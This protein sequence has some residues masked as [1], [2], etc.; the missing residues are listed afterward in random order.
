LIFRGRWEYT[1]DGILDRSH[2]RFFTLDSIQGMLKE[3]GY[4]TEGL[5]KRSSGAHWVRWIHR[6][7]GSRLIEF[8]VRQYIIV[9]RKR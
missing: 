1:D 8:L 6:L 4:E 9:A 5:T 2:L 7:L 3:A